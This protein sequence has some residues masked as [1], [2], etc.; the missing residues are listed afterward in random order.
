MTTTVANQSFRAG[1]LRPPRLIVLH[2][3]EAPCERGKALAVAQFL[4][5]PDIQASAHW[6][7]DPF[8]TVEQI[9]EA[10]TAW[11]APGANADGIQIEQCGFAGWTTADW[12][13]SPA[14]QMMRTQLVPLLRD[15]SNRWNIPL[16]PLT[17]AQIKDGTSRG[18]VTHVQINDAF[19]LSD[20]WDCGPN[21]PMTSVLEWTNSTGSAASSIMTPQ[22][23]AK[24]DRVLSYLSADNPR[25]LI[26]SATVSTSW[27]IP[28]GVP[29]ISERYS[30][31]FLAELT[32][33]AE[34]KTASTAPVG[35][36]QLTTVQ[37]ATELAKRL[38][39]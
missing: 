5:R 37:L 26:P 10:D 29:A 21:F 32:R 2:T 23:E 27:Q 11:A 9:A 31:Q 4:A 20:H 39:K 24:L 17:T 13:A 15:I 38:S 35:I 22:Q 12:A 18:V 19:G 1:R 8:E 6:V 7:I 34:A 33:M 25:G 28:A 14:Q 36:D 30:W 3:A 16:V